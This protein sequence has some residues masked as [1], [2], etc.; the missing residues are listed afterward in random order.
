MISNR[1]MGP[2]TVSVMTEGDRE[3]GSVATSRRVVAGLTLRAAQTSSRSPLC[4]PQP[5]GKGGVAGVDEAVP[6]VD[7]VQ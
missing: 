6:V 7:A 5:L 4:P 3:N 1:A 2:F